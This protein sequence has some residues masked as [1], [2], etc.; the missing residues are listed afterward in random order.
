MSLI[1]VKDLHFSYEN[2]PEILKGLNLSFDTRSTAIIGQNGAGKTTFVKLLKGL[3]KPTSGEIVV[4]GINT[5][6]ATVAKLAAH[7]GLVFQ[8]P[9][10]QI[11]KSVVYDE[12]LF[13]PLNV[14]QT[15]QEAEKNTIESLEA[16]GLS[17][18]IKAN[19]YDLTLSERKLV[20]IASILAMKTEIVI[21]DEPTIAQDYLGKQRIKALIKRLEQEGKLVISILHDM[22]FVGEAFQRTIVFQNGGASMDDDTKAVFANT[23]ALYN[24][25]LEPPHV[26]QVCNALGY[27][28]VFLTVDEFVNDRKR[29]RNAQS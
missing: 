15:Q 16:V 6:K 27:P 29:N 5:K 28:E 9:N 26:T 19:P 12:V 18:K 13:G 21:L 3:L 14:G 2:G 20:S 22:D 11:F 8:N 25:Y 23:D 4:N 7:I 1:E 17:D 10:D 24:A